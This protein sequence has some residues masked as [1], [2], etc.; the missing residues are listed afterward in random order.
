MSIDTSPQR[1]VIPT[2]RSVTTEVTT[3]P[4]ESAEQAHA[5]ALG[6]DR[7]QS[8]SGSVYVP[9]NTTF[10]DYPSSRLMFD[11]GYRHYVAVLRPLHLLLI[12]AGMLVFIAGLS[13]A[14]FVFFANDGSVLLGIL[15]ILGGILVALL[16]GLGGSSMINKRRLNIDPEERPVVQSPGQDR[17]VSEMEMNR[18]S[19]EAYQ[20]L[21][22]RQTRTSYRVAQVSIFLGFAMLLAGAWFAITASDTTAQI[23]VGSLAA[24]GS[25]ISGYIGATSIRM[26]R[27]AQA[28]M[29]FY[30]AQPLVQSYILQA[31][32]LTKALSLPRK[33]VAVERI[34]HQTLEVASV[35][36]S[37]I[38]GQ[39]EPHSSSERRSQARTATKVAAPTQV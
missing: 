23:I 18:R 25:T 21:T 12:T 17:D 37:L 19:L 4:E 2:D 26:Y 6:A 29:N 13:I 36:G 16:L 32:Q 10:E 39:D 30:Y 8:L 1:E 28:Q 11:E 22:Q 20:K 14:W 5:D 7:S 3:Q 34:I 27:R 33:D 15:T 24:I 35:A 31:V 38:R 9:P